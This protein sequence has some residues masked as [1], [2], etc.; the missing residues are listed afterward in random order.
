M[1]QDAWKNFEMSGKVADYLAYRQIPN[2]EGK[3]EQTGAMTEAE[4]GIG[5]YGTEHSSDGNG[6][7]CHADWR[8]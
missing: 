3:Q 8:V 2:Q 6:F 7:K 5:S 4:R 1:T